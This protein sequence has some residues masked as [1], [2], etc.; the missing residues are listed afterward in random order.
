LL[1]VLISV[2]GTAL[3]SRVLGMTVM[4]SIDVLAIVLFGLLFGHLV[5]A[6][7]LA[8]AGFVRGVRG[9]STA[10]CSP[11]RYET[12]PKRSRTAVVMVVR[13]EEIGRIQAG[14]RAMFQ[15]LGRSG[16]LDRY[17][18]F[19]LSDST[20]PAMGGAEER[21]VRA[22]IDELGAVGRI[23]YRRR[24]TNEG[25][26]SGN[27][28]D[29]CER[30]GREFDYMVVLD[31]DSLLEGQT[32]RELVRRMDAAPRVGIL[33]VPTRPVNRTSLFGRIHQF[34]A[35]VYGPL[36]TDGLAFWLG[37]S[38]PYWGHN[39]IIRVRPFMR[40]C[41]LPRLPGREPFGGEILSHDFVE[42]ALMRRAGWEV[43]L[44]ADLGGSYEEVPANL[45][46]YAARDR[47]WCQ[48]NLQ[49]LRLVALPGLRVG[50]RITFAVGALS[51]LCG[52]AWVLFALMLLYPR[53]V[54]AGMAA[55]PGGAQWGSAT[56]LLAIVLALLFVPKVLAVIRLASRP[57]GLQALGGAKAVAASVLGE[58]VFAALLAPIQLV[59]HTQFVVAILLHRTVGWRTQ[60]RHDEDTTLK[61]AI[62]V[63]AG[64]TVFAALLG[65][66]AYL[67]DPV[68]CL[69]LI[70]SM[71]GLLLAIPISVL[72]S[73]SQWGLRARRWGLFRIPEEIA[74]PP[75][76]HALTAATVSI[77]GMRDQPSLAEKCLTA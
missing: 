48:G 61:E 26:K 77:P 47:R 64:H 60:P 49:H 70:P 2:G 68:L 21:A 35:A 73:Y 16:P 57:G 23:V 37:G 51:Y 10:T 44:A 42:G 8:I 39:A 75:V 65:G 27:L 25:R 62:Q 3:F 17:V 5:S 56:I 13:H 4:T 71:I 31:A 41:R 59:F 6:F 52:P 28:A 38:A 30:W 12:R 32:I 22:L 46:T 33:Q 24:A 14:L 29:F 58:S 63:H 36:V 15:S 53:Q 34:A 66:L 45:I 72:S 67:V 11:W 55:D 1:V 76:L 54:L 74:T 18:L 69:W 40:H 9:D 20:D 7:L 50:S 43:R 19:I